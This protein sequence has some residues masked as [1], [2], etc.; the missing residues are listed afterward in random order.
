MELEGKIA[1]MEAEK[2]KLVYEVKRGE[3]M[4]SG[5]NGSG[6]GGGGGS[7]GGEW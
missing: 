2:A 7:G 5:G 3:R 1:E 6:G 4:V